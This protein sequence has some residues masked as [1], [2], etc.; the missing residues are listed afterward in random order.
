VLRALVGAVAA[1]TAAGSGTGSPAAGA[2]VGLRAEAL[3]SVIVL[4]VEPVGCV[5][6]P[7]DTATWQPVLL[8]ATDPEAGVD[9]YVAA[10]LLAE[11]GGDLWA[12]AGPR[13]VVRL[14]AAENQQ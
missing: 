7:L 4:R 5:D 2:A 3:S 6:L 14:P 11:Q 9:L 12:A 10:R 1:Q 8:E 13:F